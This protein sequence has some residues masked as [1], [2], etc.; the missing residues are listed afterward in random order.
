MTLLLQFCLEPSERKAVGALKG[1]IGRTESNEVEGVRGERETEG[2]RE[3]TVT[4][5]Q[6]TTGN[7]LPDNRNTTTDE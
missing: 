3:S 5:E 2:E 4:S 6:A 1:F 7:S